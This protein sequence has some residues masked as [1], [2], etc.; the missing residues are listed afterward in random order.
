M[1]ERLPQSYLAPHNPSPPRRG[2][3]CRCPLSVAR[4]NR[5]IFRS[6]RYS[7]DRS[8][9]RRHVRNACAVHDACAPSWFAQRPTD[10]GKHRALPTTACYWHTCFPSSKMSSHRSTIPQNPAW[11]KWLSSLS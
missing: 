1:S 8:P 2:H 4:R 6:G 9:R 7:V 3:C 11:P 5:A 10:F